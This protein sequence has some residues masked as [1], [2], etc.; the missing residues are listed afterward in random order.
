MGKAAGI[1]GDVER[2]RGRSQLC[3]QG[4]R[5]RRGGRDGEVWVW[6]RV[7]ALVW[8]WKWKWQARS[9]RAARAGTLA[10]VSSCLAGH[11]GTGRGGRAPR[12][13]RT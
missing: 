12:P 13:Q 6:V 3:A 11:A 8:A 1:N 10:A 9:G 2:G 7:W 4:E 5:E